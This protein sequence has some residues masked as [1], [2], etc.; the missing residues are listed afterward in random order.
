[1]H[2]LSICKY[3]FI[4]NVYYTIINDINCIF[5]KLNSIEIIIINTL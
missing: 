5:Y 3:S 1:M 4:T 2:I